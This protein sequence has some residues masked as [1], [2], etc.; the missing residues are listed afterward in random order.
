MQTN[1]T[2]IDCEAEEVHTDIKGVR[3]NAGCGVEEESC[4]INVA[5]PPRHLNSGLQQW[6]QQRQGQPQPQWQRPQQVQ[7]QQSWNSHNTER[8]DE[9]KKEDKN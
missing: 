1:K 6:R 2:N 3:S 5:S 7:K 8:G 4:D 9:E